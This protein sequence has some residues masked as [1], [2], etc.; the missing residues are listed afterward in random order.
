MILEIFYDKQCPFCIKRAEWIKKRDIHNHIHLS[1]IHRDGFI[2]EIL[3]VPLEESLKDIHAIHKDGKI[4]KGADVVRSVL[5][6][7]EYK[8]TLWIINLPVISTIF[9]WTFYAISNNRHKIMW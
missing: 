2:L 6:I 4:I 8:K 9:K 5:N 3:G 7:L 1:D